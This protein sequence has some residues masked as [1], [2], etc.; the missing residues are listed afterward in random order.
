MGSHME[1][2]C[3]RASLMTIDFLLL[4]EKSMGKMFENWKIYIVFGQVYK[5]YS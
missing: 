1:A 2:L 5:E 3:G 4:I